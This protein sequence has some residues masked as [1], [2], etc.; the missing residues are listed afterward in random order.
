M[1]MARANAHLRAA[2]GGQHDE[3]E[4][5]E[6]D[7]GGNGEEA[8]DEEEGDEDGADE[9]GQADQVLLDELDAGADAGGVVQVGGE[10][11]FDRIGE[12]EGIAD[13]AFAGDADEGDLIRIA[14]ERAG[15]V[16]VEDEAADEEVIAPSA[17]DGGIAHDAEDGEIARLVADED[18]DGIAGSGFD[19][20]GEA[21][22]DVGVVPVEGGGGDGFAIEG[23]EGVEVIDVG[24]VD[25]DDLGCGLGE[26]ALG[27]EDGEGADED[28]GDAVDIGVVGEGG[29]EVPDGAIG[30]VGGGAIG[31]GGVFAVVGDDEID[32]FERFV[33]FVGDGVA[34]GVSGGEG[35]ADDEGG[36]HEADDDEGRL[37]L[38]PDQ[39]A[40][41]HAEEDGLAPGDPRDRAHGDGEED[42]EADEDPG[43][44][45][46]EEA[47]PWG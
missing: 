42:E 4:E 25:A 14:I 34:D 32:V 11:V 5:D 28:A 31:A 18:A 44:G 1:P 27:V 17:G 33:D 2:L 8:E 19:G 22:G 45:D 7:A 24:G 43:E 40:Q 30:E 13:A 16:Q 23:A 9:L 20:F 46:P 38:T 21:V 15:G 41:P 35:G 10:L 39:V 6:H 12:R 29:L 26:A 37:G 3:D 47:V 36:E